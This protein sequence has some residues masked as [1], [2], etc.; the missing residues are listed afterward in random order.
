VQTQFHLF[1]GYLVKKTQLHAQTS[2]F[3]TSKHLYANQYAK[4]SKE[5]N[6]TNLLAENFGEV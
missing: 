5:F 4:Y 3:L 6:I 1:P 2:S